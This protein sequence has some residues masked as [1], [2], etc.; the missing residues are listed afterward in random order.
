MADA[1]LDG[2]SIE[3]ATLES[4]PGAIDRDLLEQLRVL[5][6][7]SALAR[8]NEE[9]KDAAPRFW[10]HLRVLE[11]IGR[12]AFGEVYRAWDTRLDREVAL[13][14]LPPDNAG[15]D[16]ASS[17]I[18][19]GRLLAR[20]RHPNVVTIYGAERIG[21]RIG[22]WMEFVRGRT[23]EQ[24]LGDGA[25]FTADDVVRLG[26]ELCRA[27]AAV[28]GAGLLHRDI[29]A[30]NVMVADDGRLLLMD[31]GAGYELAKGSEGSVAGTPFYLAP[32]VL[33]GG[34]PTT[35]SDIYS[36]GVLLYHLVTGAFPV[37][38]STLAELRRA[39]AQ[40]E[41][42]DL[43]S[44]GGGLPPR[45][46]RVIK[47]AIEPEPHLR[48]DTAEAFEA[49]LAA[50]SRSN[51][52]FVPYA[53]GIVLALMV[54]GIGWWVTRGEVGP[55][56][57]GSSLAGSNAAPTPRVQRFVQPA[58]SSRAEPWH[59]LVTDGARVYFLERSGAGWQVM[60]TS[61]GAEP[62]KPFAVPFRYTRIYDISRERSEFLIGRFEAFGPGLPLWI[63]PA[64]GGQ[65]VRVGDILVD[66]ALWV[67]DGTGI[68]YVRGRDVWRVG[69][70]GRDARTLLRAS[71]D[72]QLLR[73][74]PDGSRI[75]YTVSDSKT[76]TLSLWEMNAD[77]S[78][79]KVRVGAASRADNVC[80][81]SWTADGR[82][83]IYSLS[84]DGVYNLWVRPDAR[85]ALPW[86][87]STSIQLT[88]NAT[89]TF[90]SLMID[91]DE[92]MFAFV[93]GTRF[94]SVQ[95]SPAT[96]DYVPFLPDTEVLWPQ[97]SPDSR[98]VAFQRVTDRTIWRSRADGSNPIQ[99][100]GAPLRAARPRWSP[101][102]TTIAFEAVSPGNPMR[103]YVVSI[104]G[105]PAEEIA[106][107]Q[108]G[109]HSLP[110]WSPD[111]RSIALAVN[112]RRADV[113]AAERGIFIVERATRGA[114]RLAGSEG[115]TAPFWSPDGRHLIAQTLDQ[116][117]VLRFDA[118]ANEWVE[119]AHGR[120]LSGPTWS[121]DSRHL[122]VQDIRESGSPVYRLR[123][124]DFSRDGEF[125]LEP[126]L[127]HGFQIA[128]FQG[129][130]PDGSLIVQLSRT[131]TQLH[132]IDL[133]WR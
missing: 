52:L 43:P 35:G 13:K 15:S 76:E 97:F 6:S 66:E 109:T 89:S 2:T 27:V 63:W 133:T 40:R 49:D 67:P 65:P 37:R 73:F 19:E 14:L 12:G 92:R 80:C 116:G 28:H 81:G 30:Q 62:P 119:I 7:V 98:H 32:E 90:A 84:K 38:A 68:V 50:A 105:G 64:S 128:A 42:I 34:A 106:P 82:Y 129:L 60:Q 94:E 121:P 55:A 124:P 111:G 24:M 117:R 20:V 123:V 70:D 18:E 9:S 44:R 56:R 93:A 103:A 21:D 114:T 131:G 69:R 23:L 125:S 59:P 51:R 74:S 110:A 1:I 54:T 53:A 100:V 115:L 87:G 96:G 61:A 4:H 104:D 33:F 41:R 78:D 36:I 10:G 77:G 95:Y 120:S 71:G 17:I 108:Q 26:S 22:L 5:A 47:T 127:R 113:P 48:Y 126:L 57:D 86:D 11:G 75:S 3:W 8:S 45:L 101:D 83:F 31:F 85:G 99:L 107:R 79:P 112:V 130:T 16:P 122:Y 102:G 118:A 29:K 132:A 58:V 25:V 91:N 88:T 39:H 72:P 46:A